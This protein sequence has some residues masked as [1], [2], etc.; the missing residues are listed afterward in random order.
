MRDVNNGWLVRYLHSNT[1]SAFFFLVFIHIGRGMY[2]GSYR[3]PR[4]LVWAIGTIILIA[5]MATGENTWPNLLL[6]YQDESNLLFSSIILPFNKNRTRAIKRV[7]PHNI[8]VLSLLICGLLGDCWGN[9]IKGA[10][11]DS[12]R[13]ILE[14]GIKNSAYIHHLNLRL[15]ELGYCSTVTPKLVVK[16]ES[17]QDKRIDPTLT[18]YN[19][20]LTTYTFTSFLWIFNAFYMEVNGVMV[21]RI[22]SWVGE[23]ITPLG[24]AHLIMGIGS[25][26]S[27][28]L[29]L[30]INDVKGLQIVKTVLKNRYNVDSTIISFF[31]E[32]ESIKVLCITEEYFFLLRS[33]VNPYLHESFSHLFITVN[34]LGSSTSYASSSIKAKAIY[35]NA[36][37]QKELAIKQNRFRSG[38]YRWTNKISGKSYVGS[39]VN[40]SKRLNNYYN[41]K[42]LADPKNNMLIY[43]ALLKYGYSK[44]MLEILEYCEKSC[45]IEREQYYLDLLKPEYNILQKA[46][47]TLWFKH[48]EE[49]KSKMRVKSPENLI[50]IRNHIKKLNSTSFSPEVRKRISAGMANFNILTKGRKIVFTNIETQEVLTFISMRDAALKMNISRNT[51]TKY[52]SSQEVYGKYKISLV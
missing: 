2:Y 19:Y 28:G 23:F 1:A 41:Y 6:D 27:Q 13:F 46:R 25:I 51:N 14:Q 31:S 50:I 15:H 45:L 9:K 26:E 21:K 24:L 48:S 52:L 40:L 43:K 5:M 34:L 32:G 35:A 11:M 8:E 38:V 36:D 7:G 3:L 4:T 29:I 18:R 49:T 33:I 22:P 37:I 47:S 17:I 12:V 20:R 42:T 44:F 39:S 10:Q 30:K 16:S